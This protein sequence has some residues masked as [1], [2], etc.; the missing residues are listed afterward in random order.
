M[1]NIPG[2]LVLPH[3]MVDLAYLEEDAILRVYKMEGH[4]SFCRNPLFL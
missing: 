1:C 4:R 2:V 3:N